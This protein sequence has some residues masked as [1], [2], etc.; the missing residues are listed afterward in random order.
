MPQS[1]P[2]ETPQSLAEFAGAH[3]SKP[4]TIS[5]MDRLPEQVRE[6]IMT[7]MRAGVTAGQVRRWLIHVKG[8]KPATLPAEDALRRWFNK[9]GR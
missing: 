9:Q 4:G 2:A 8:M 3:P 6:E 1:D 5:F 7:N